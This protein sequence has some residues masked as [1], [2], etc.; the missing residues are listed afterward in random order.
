MRK[1]LVLVLGLTTPLV[2]SSADI[3]AGRTKATACMACHGANGVSVSDDIPNLAGQKAVYLKTQLGAFRAG[4]RKNPLMNAIAAQLGDADID[5]VAA[6]FGS[7]TTP[8][9]TELSAL[10][11]AL[12]EQKISFPE[13]YRERFVLYS[14][15][16]QA[17][18]KRVRHNYANAA[19]MNGPD[20]AG[21][22][23]NGAYVLTEIYKAK[24]DDAGN[25]VKAE[26]G[27][28]VADKLLV[29]AAMEKRANWGAEIP[30]E[31][32]NGDWNYALFTPAKAHRDINQAKCLACHK[33]LHEADYLFSYKD[34]VSQA[35]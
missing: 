19:A 33:P 5:N 14:K 2:V 8:D 17:G 25:P 7:L 16:D 13:S 31:I 20:S 35:R 1:G 30:E 28:Y 27:F 18:P 26:D 23:P 15:V 4:T 22:L 10:G 9:E 6:F 21:N 3:D 24:L 29:F 12:N 32:R 11:V 34:L